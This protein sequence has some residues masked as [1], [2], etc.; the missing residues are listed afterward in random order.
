MTERWGWGAGLVSG[1]SLPLLYS[2]EATGGGWGSVIMVLAGGLIAMVASRAAPLPTQTGTASECARLGSSLAELC[3]TGAA[4]FSQASRVDS[5]MGAGLCAVP[6]F[7]A[8]CMHGTS[9]AQYQRYTR[10]LVSFLGLGVLAYGTFIAFEG[11]GAAAPATGVPDGGVALLTLLNAAYA[12]S[13]GS[14]SAIAARAS[15]FASLAAQPSALGPL[16]RQRQGWGLFAVQMAMLVHSM[17]ARAGEARASIAELRKGAGAEEVP[18]ASRSQRSLM[19]CA[20][21]ALT[22]SFAFQWRSWR[23][24]LYAVAGLQ[25][26]WGCL[27]AYKGGR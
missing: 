19:L 18:R 8:V 1:S 22:V 14:A 6:L 15:V 21:S 16:L 4:V 27:W 13:G 11:G 12:C 26:S 7:H 24:G 10:A 25:A 20:A 2:L 17:L 9:D 3:L 5:D 23:V